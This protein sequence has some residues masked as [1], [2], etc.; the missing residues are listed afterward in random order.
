LFAEAL[1]VDAA[2]V[3]AEID[4]GG[5]EA[6]PPAAGTVCATCEGACC[7]GGG[8]HAFMD[9]ALI[10]RFRTARPAASTEDFVAT[11]RTYLPRYSFEGSCVYHTR[12][13]CALPRAL[14]ADMCNHYRCSG[15]KKA[16]ER[17]VRDGALRVYVVVREDNRIRRSAFVDG[18]TIRRYSMPEDGDRRC[19]AEREAS[20][21]ALGCAA[22]GETTTPIPARG[23]AG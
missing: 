22:P 15:L 18:S 6:Q 2:P 1:Q 5:G 11:Y 16:E 23:G 20:L 3:E 12:V 14:R 7:H 19:S 4:A 21:N 10:Q 17:I 9:A 8:V 13:G